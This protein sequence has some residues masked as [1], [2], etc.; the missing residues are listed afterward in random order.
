[1]HQDLGYAPSPPPFR[2]LGMNG[3]DESCA[4]EP[5]TTVTDTIIRGWYYGPVVT[6]NGTVSVMLKHGIRV[7]ISV[8][9]ALRVV[10]F[11]KE[12]TAVISGD[13]DRS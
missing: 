1:M 6:T 13:G 2:P 7:D 5:H 4:D 11:D 12:C 3:V 9:H 8:D 10:N